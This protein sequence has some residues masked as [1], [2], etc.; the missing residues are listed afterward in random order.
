MRRWE[1]YVEALQSLGAAG[2]S[3]PCC[4]VKL[5]L[6]SPVSLPAAMSWPLGLMASLVMEPLRHLNVAT[7]SG[8]RLS[9][10]LT[11]VS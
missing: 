2:V 5:T 4:V 10:I 3:E 11:L 1:G 7:G 8:L 6:I 9:Q